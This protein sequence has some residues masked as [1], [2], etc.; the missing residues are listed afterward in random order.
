MLTY[1][2]GFATR[3]EILFFIS[4]AISDRI[5][6]IYMEHHIRRILP[7]VLAR[8]VIPLQNTPA[9]GIPPFT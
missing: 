5:F 1:I 6:V 7:T 9:F 3:D 4:S 8:E 2:A